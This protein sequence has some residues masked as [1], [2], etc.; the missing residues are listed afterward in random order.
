MLTSLARSSVL[1]LTNKSGSAVGQGDVI[2][3]DTANASA[4]KTTTTAGDV[5][6]VTGVVLEPNGIANNATGM[7]AIMG[8]VPKITLSGAGSIG[9][10]VKTHTVAGQG[11]RHAAPRAAGDFA[12]VLGTSSTPEAILFG[13]TPTLSGTSYT[14]PTVLGTYSASAAATLDITTRN[15]SGVSGAIFQTDFAYYQV[16]LE[17]IVPATDNVQLY[18][19]FSED[20]GATYRATAGDYFYH[21]FWSA[22]TPTSGTFNDSSFV[23]TAFAIAVAVDTTIA[24]AGLMG[25]NGELK[26]TKPA[27]AQNH[28]VAWDTQFYGNTPRFEQDRGSGWYTR[29]NAVN[30]MRLLFSSGNITSGNVTIIGIP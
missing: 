9:D 16:I 25:V 5:T 19:R 18:V 3:I 21:T 11:V 28:K 26:L 17:D 13:P 23:S 4:F 24:T 2:I 1:P 20:G 14:F 29:S 8:Y 12:Q 27:T 7:V 10:F 30:A 6:S 15:A 22:N